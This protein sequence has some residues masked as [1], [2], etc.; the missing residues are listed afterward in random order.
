MIIENLSRAVNFL[1][2]ER[3]PGV[4]FQKQAFLSGPSRRRIDSS[5]RTPEWGPIGGGKQIRCL[6]EK[7][8]MVGC[9]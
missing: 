6:S 8:T 4:A 5:E 7:D 9:P 2:V 1:A 3:I